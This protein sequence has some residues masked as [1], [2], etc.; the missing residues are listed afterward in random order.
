MK[1][2][3]LLVIRF[4]AM[5]DVAL[6]IPVLLAVLDNYPK[7]NI[8]LITRSFYA[9]WIPYHPRLK[10]IGVDLNQYRGAFGL[11]KLANEL[12]K[13]YYFDT[14]IDLHNV[15]RTKILYIIFKLKR[16]K[17]FTINKLR[18]ERKKIINHRSTAQLPHIT[19]RYCLVFEQAGYK[20][21]I[22]NAPWIIPQ[23]NEELTN[24]LTVN[25]LLKKT[26]QWIGIAPFATHYSKVW[27]LDKIEILIEKLIREEYTV[28]LFGGGKEEIIQLSNLSKKH[29][30]TLL[31]AG[32]ISF[33]Q[34]LALMKKLDLMITM[35][36]SNMHFASLVGTKV[37]SIWGATTPLIGF[38]PLNN[39]DHIIQVPDSQ[40]QLLTISTYG[41]K[42]PN[43]GY[44]WKSQIL[45]EEVFKKV[46]SLV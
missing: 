13:K 27:G 14:I 42:Q 23:K 31:I 26:N 22:G 10:V 6:T 28:F 45:P 24:Y 3:N 30:N 25:D 38:Y 33:D 36:S 32:E 21:K 18:K 43:N 2:E 17:I 40:R 41:K 16:Y 35:D 44:D 46:K 37:V 11:I 8:V 39:Q 12:E 7:V 9:S 4:S 1:K 29:K 5:G 20:V 19:S 15:L 34:E